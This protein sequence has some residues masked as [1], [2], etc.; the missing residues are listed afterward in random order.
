MRDPD[1]KTKR[2]AVICSEERRFLLFDYGILYAVSRAARSGGV[3]GTTSSPSM[4]V[5]GKEV[6]RMKNNKTYYSYRVQLE[7]LKIKTWFLIVLARLLFFLALL[8]THYLGLK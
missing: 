4:S 7:K 5:H 8:V 2:E 3:E 1:P 6:I